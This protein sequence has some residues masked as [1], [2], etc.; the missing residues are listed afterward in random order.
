[1]P[2]RCSGRTAPGRC[3]SSPMRADRRTRTYQL[4]RL[5][6]GELGSEWA[7]AAPLPAGAPFVLLDEHVVPVARGLDM[8]GRTH[9]T[10]HRRGKPR[11]R[12]SERGRDRAATPSATA[13]EP[14][15]PVH[16]TA[17]RDAGGVRF[18]W[19]TRKRGACRRY[20]CGRVPTRRRRAKP[21]SSKSC[22]AL[23]VV[24][25]L[26]ATAPSTLY[27]AADEI[28]DFGAAQSSLDRAPLPNFGGRRP[29]F[30]RHRNAHPIEIS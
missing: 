16:L 2:R 20:L 29:R 27:A 14:L 7:M 9:A 13:L 19:R 24:R 23:S 26:S 8:L 30:A 10:A 11:S 28:A 25:T 6:R 18:S 22:P 3:C 5:L 12:R 21:T 17:S 4:S 15:A 1:M